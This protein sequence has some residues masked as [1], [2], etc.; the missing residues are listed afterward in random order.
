MVLRMRDYTRARSFSCMI[1]TLLID[2]TYVLFGSYSKL[3]GR[4]SV[5]DD[6]VVRIFVVLIA[7]RLEKLFA[8][9]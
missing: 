8:I 5:E 4:K 2:N 9:Y 6:F 1:K 7:R 3:N